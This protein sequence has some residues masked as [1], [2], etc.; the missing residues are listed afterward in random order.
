MKRILYFGASAL[1]L[2]FTNCSADDLVQDQNQPVTTNQT[3]YVNMRI[4]GD[5]VSGSRAP[6]AD[7]A[8][9]PQAEDDFED[10]G[11][12]GENIVNNAYFVFYDE[13]GAVVGDIVN[14]DLATLKEEQNVNG[15]TVEK[16]YSSVVPVSVKKGEKKPTQVI[17]YIN[18][19]SPSTLNRSLDEIQNVARAAIYTNDG[20]GENAKK[21]F[22]MSNSVYY[23][24][25]T[26]DAIPQIAV[27]IP[28]TQLY[29][30]EQAAKDALGSGNTV[31][32][33]VERYAAKLKFAAVD[34]TDYKTGTRVYG[35]NSGYEVKPITL[36]FVPQFWAVNAESKNTYVIKSFHEETDYDA[37]LGKNYTYSKLNDRINL[38]DVNLLPGAEGNLL[39]N[40]NMWKWNNP[41]YHRSYW[42]MS[43]CYF[44][45]QYPEVSSDLNDIGINNIQQKY[46]SYNELADGDKGYKV[47]DATAK[48]AHYFK[49][50]TVGRMA[51][52]SANPVAAVASVIYVGK[53][54]LTLDETEL[55]D[56]T[57]FY[58]YMAGPVPNATADEKLG[59]RPYIYF[60]GKDK[61]TV[62]AVDGGE[63]MFKRFLAQATILYKP[64]YKKDA[65]GKD[66]DEIIDFT[67]FSIYDPMDIAKLTVA[68]EVSEIPDDVKKAYDG[69]ADTK[70]KLQNNTRTLQFKGVDE[71]QSQDIYIVSNNGYNK[72]VNT[73][74]GENTNEVTLLEANVIL[75]KQVGFS[76]YYTAGHAYFNAP[77]KHFGWY[78]KGNEQKSADKINWNLVRVGDFGM[79][80]NHSYTMNVTEIVGLGQGIGND[81]NPIVPPS[82]S[83][84]YFMA[85]SVNIL[86]WA[87]VPVQNQKL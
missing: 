22:A 30:S 10:G 13:T 41:G 1:A 66:T 62:S 60:D 14:I 73:K 74:S 77:I 38:K 19:I 45:T 59:D 6:V 39:D 18:P 68:L 16:T 67:R 85:Y 82:T 57:S 25:E 69:K 2:L 65:D 55:P 29:T 24:E 52:K 71:A 27:P 43:P 23:P 76:Y 33:Y 70:L 32:I 49:E 40:E 53:Y 17:C 50:T 3:L 47:T 64:V 44:Q 86:K 34:P 84:D 37:F 31:D 51:L 26:A 46:I 5:A 48:E 72:I 78:R 36:K 61:S 58:T 75:A 20:T 21:Y 63:S 9:N 11:P 4:S 80:R 56:G 7:V 83:E 81:D 79:V 28:S 87:V 35:E 54:T 12:L 15:A 42:G 8:G